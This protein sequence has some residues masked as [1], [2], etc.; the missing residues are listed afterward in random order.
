[1]MRVGNASPVGVLI[2]DD[3]DWAW[4]EMHF[5]GPGFTGLGYVLG[6]MKARGCVPATRGA[7]GAESPAPLV[8]AR[9]LK[10]ARIQRPAVIDGPARHQETVLPGRRRL[11]EHGPYSYQKL[12]PTKFG[13]ACPR[14]NR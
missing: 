3:G 9:H 10:R 12:T 11:N 8:V 7:D 14:R 4:A 13:L 6:R 5:P 1:M 2:Q